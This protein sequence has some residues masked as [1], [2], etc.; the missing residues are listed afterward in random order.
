MKQLW[1]RVCSISTYTK[2]LALL[3]LLAIAVGLLPLSGRVALLPGDA[4]PT[5]VLPRIELDPALP[6][7]GQAVQ[8][9]VQDTAALPNVLLTVDG[10]A[11]YPSS[12]QTTEDGLAPWEWTWQVETP[13]ARDYDLI[14]YHD[15]DSGCIERARWSVGQ[16]AERP[17]ERT[18]TKL[19]VVFANPGREWH[20][21]S[22]WDVELAYARLV[23]ADHWGVDDLAQRVQQASAAGL[24]VILRVD[25]DQGQSLPPPGDPVALNEYS[26]SCAGWRAMNVC[27]TCMRYRSVPATTPRTPMLSP[28]TTR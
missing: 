27:A 14:L 12:W 15:C 20:G 4:Q 7:P 22:A 8:I 21:K 17:T 19:G 6:L 3:I 13:F 16:R 23:D 2:V 28:R 24:R 18:P 25:Y 9:T 5:T 1:T 11:V 26:I 10:A